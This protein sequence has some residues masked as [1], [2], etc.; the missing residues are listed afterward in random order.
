MYKGKYL[1]TISDV[2]LHLPMNRWM[3]LHD[4]IGRVQESDIGKQVW[5]NDGIVYVE[6]EEQR[7]ARLKSKKPDF[8][9]ISSLLNDAKEAQDKYFAIIKPIMETVEE[10]L[11]KK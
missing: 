3:M 4:V 9:K 10:E 7:D 5:R 8:A 1:F 6:S 2:D 11:A